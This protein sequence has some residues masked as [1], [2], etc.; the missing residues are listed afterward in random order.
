MSD[1]QDRAIRE[2]KDAIKWHQK[3]EWEQGQEIKHLRSALERIRDGQTD[4]STHEEAALNYRHIAKEA[5]RVR[6]T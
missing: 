3:F 1:Y 6:E 5:L 2:Y 4:A